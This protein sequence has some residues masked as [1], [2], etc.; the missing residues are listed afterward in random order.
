MVKHLLSLDS[1]FPF[2]NALSVTQ[3]PSGRETVSVQVERR[4]DEMKD[5]R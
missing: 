1:S 3:D 5:E 2:L 4:G